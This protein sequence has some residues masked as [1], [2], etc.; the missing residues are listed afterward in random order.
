MMTAPALTGGARAPLKTY[1]VR[2]TLPDGQR[3]AYRALAGSSIAALQ[4]ALE[5]H[6][7]SRI[8]IHPALRKMK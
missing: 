3:I 6:G 4:A 2:V 5:T 8:V 7:I 1:A